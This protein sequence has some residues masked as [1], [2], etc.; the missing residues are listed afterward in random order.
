MADALK[1]LHSKHVIHRDIKPENL[2]N[3]SVFFLLLD[4]LINFR[5][6]LKSLILDG[7]FMLQPIKDKLFVGLLITFRLKWLRIVL[8]IIG[9]TFGVLEF[10]AMSSVQV[11]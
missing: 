1:Y 9:L 6:S 7:Q 5:G 10:Y 4:Y 11:K 2:L 3:S 8:M